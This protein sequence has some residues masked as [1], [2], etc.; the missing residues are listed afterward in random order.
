MSIF[1]EATTTNGTRLIPFKRGAFQGMRTV[2]PSFFTISSGQISPTYEA[3]SPIVLQILMSA[4][5]YVRC[6][7][8]VVL[9]EF[10]PNPKMLEL[11]ADK[12]ECPWEIYAWCVRD[13]I[14][15]YSGIQKLDEKLCLKDRLAFISLMSGEVDSAEING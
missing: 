13:A 4:S 12:G 3:F 14:S 5:L 9:P 6:S 11:H 7:T 2:T 10:T 1:A 8:L 15:K